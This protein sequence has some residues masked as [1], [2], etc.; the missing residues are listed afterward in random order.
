[1][2][3]WRGRLALALSV[4]GLLGCGKRGDPRPPLRVVPQPVAEFRLA[5]RGE[6]LEISGVAPTATTAGERLPVLDL[7][8][9]RVDGPGDFERLA[10]RAARKLA[11]GEAFLDSEPLPPAGSLVRVAAV[12]SV[13]GRPSARTS[14]LSLTTWTPLAPPTALAATLTLEGVALSWTPASIQPAP[15][16]P[17]TP[18]PTPLGARAAAAPA[19]GPVAGVVSA[20]SPAASATPS[21]AVPST[22]PSAEP[23]ASPSP[24]T[25]PPVETVPPA[26]APGPAPSV[27]PTPASGTGPA[28]TPGP[29]ALA[30]GPAAS[31]APSPS[32]TPPTTGFWIYRRAKDGVARRPLVAQLTQG[33]TYLDAAVQPGE[34]WCYSVRFV[35]QA[36]PPVESAAS[37]EACVGIRDIAAPA[38]P[39]GLALVREAQA[40]E[41]SWTPSTEADLAGYRVYR[42]VEPV[43]EAEAGLIAEL[44]RQTTVFRDDTLQ[45]GLVHTY[46]VVAVDAAGNESPRSEILRV[47]P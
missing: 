47:R 5:Q 9:L 23:P 13:R 3:G 43:E 8:L 44:P 26:L 10:R 33:S 38:A 29:G 24:V 46:F 31:P 32:P 22:V 41:I 2:P 34:E 25:A 45:P 7:E 28:A 17:P 4:A 19:A 6:Q 11:P 20:P 36:S 15:P 12:A 35:A 27:S 30:P 42:A 16:V 14:V 40:V 1:M 37:N 21:A 18:L 39:A